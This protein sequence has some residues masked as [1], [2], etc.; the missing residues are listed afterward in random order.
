M[1]ALFAYVIVLAMMSVCSGRRKYSCVTSGGDHNYIISIVVYC[2]FVM[3]IMMTR[4]E[5]FD[6][7]KQNS[8]LVRV[9]DSYV[10]CRSPH[11]SL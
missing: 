3:V 1:T 9:H 2:C 11:L 4:R 5:W 8:G 6:W 10:C 7:S